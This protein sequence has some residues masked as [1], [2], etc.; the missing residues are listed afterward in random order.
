MKTKLLA[1]LLFLFPLSIMAQSCTDDAEEMTQEI[2]TYHYI[3]TKN[4]W[5]VLEIFL[6]R[7]VEAD[8]CQADC[9]DYDIAF[10]CVWSKGNWRKT[11]MAYR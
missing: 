9:S 8:V 7:E 1:A 11:L 2:R 4:N 3:I 10:H 6:E 5:S